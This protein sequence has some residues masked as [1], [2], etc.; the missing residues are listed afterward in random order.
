[1]MMMTIDLFQVTWMRNG[2]DIPKAHP[3]FK[4]EYSYRMA[5]LEIDRATV[6]TCGRFTCIAQNCMGTEETECVISVEGNKTNPTTKLLTCQSLT[7]SL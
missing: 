4:Q 5:V 7:N 3:D 2:E 1:M 6:Q